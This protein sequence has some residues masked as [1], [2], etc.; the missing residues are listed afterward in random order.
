MMLFCWLLIKINPEQVTILSLPICKMGTVRPNAAVV[1][2]IISK[3]TVSFLC[4]MV[5]MPLIRFCQQP[6]VQQNFS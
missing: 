5:Y 2:I 3:F 6:S 1:T 4:K